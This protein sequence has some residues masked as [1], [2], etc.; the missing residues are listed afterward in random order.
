MKS[1]T[2][3]CPLCCRQGRFVLQE[4]DVYLGAHPE[5]VHYL[6]LVHSLYHCQVWE[7]PSEESRII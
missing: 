2:S 6:E 7:E 1:E 5:L 4:R 3:V